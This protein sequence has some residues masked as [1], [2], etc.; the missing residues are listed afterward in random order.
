MTDI[1]RK[2]LEAITAKPGQKAKDIASGLGLDRNTINSALHGILKTKVRQ[3]NTYRWYPRDTA[4]SN[5]RLVPES[6]ELNTALARLCRYYLDCI[7]QDDLDGVSEFAAS[8]FGPPNYV[9]L[10][11]LPGL[12]P[13]G[14]DPLDS[15]SARRLVQSVRRDRNRQMMFVGYPVRLR[16][17][18]AR[19]GWEGYRVEPLLLFPCR[20]VDNRN[21]NPILTEDPLQ[22]NFKALQGLSNATD[23]NLIEEAVDL[24]EELGLANT[25]VDQPELDEV[26][27]RL[28]EIRSEWDWKEE[29]DPHAFSTGIPLSSLNEQGIYNRGILIAAER[30]P[31]TK[32]LEFELRSLQSVEE[33]KQSGTALGAWLTNQVIDSPPPAYDPLIE[34]LPLNSE[35]RQAVRQALSNPLTVITGPPGTGN[36]RQL[37]GG[38]ARPAVRLDRP[39]SEVR[40]GPGARCRERR[41][42]GAVE[43]ESTHI[44]GKAHGRF[45][46]PMS[47]AV[48]QDTQQAGSGTDSGP[49]VRVSVGDRAH[50]HE[51]QQPPPPCC[52]Y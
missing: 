29:I 24:S 16:F 19:S 28:C 1:Q 33:S 23:T 10:T 46:L 25:S 6:Q 44:H 43:R 52:S 40:R 30:S 12:D 21:A 38:W 2:I 31:Y 36:P 18:R 7:S 41:I 50:L 27:S 34:V 22:I 14:V 49:G 4:G 47:R 5:A 13:D 3:D 15:E 26:L 32:G 51:S 42:S 11:A 35:Q 39:H 8:N 37:A 17:I 20:D 45:R 48:T 9:E